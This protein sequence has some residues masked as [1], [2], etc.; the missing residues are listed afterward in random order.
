MMNPF[1]FLKK[2]FKERT[3]NPSTTT[4]QKNCTRV[5]S[6]ISRRSWRTI[7]MLVL[8]AVTFCVLSVT[9]WTM[10]LS[11]DDTINITF[12]SSNEMVKAVYKCAYEN[13]DQTV[14]MVFNIPIGGKTLLQQ[15]KNGV[16]MSKV[17]NIRSNTTSHSRDT[18]TSRTRRHH[19]K[20]K[21][22]ISLDT[23]YVI[24]TPNICPVG[25]EVTYLIIVHSATAYFAR[26]RAIRETYGGKKLF[27][28][29][30]QRVVFLLGRTTD[31]KITRSI[32]EEAF[33][34]RDIVQGH[35]LDSYHNL[36]HKGV[37]GYRWISEHCPQA[38]FIIK[39]DDDVFVN[40]FTLVRNILP[41]FQ[42]K[43]RHIVCHLRRSGTSPIIRGKSK[44]QVHD[45][46]FRGLEHFPFDYCNGYFVIITSDLIRPMLKAARL[47]PFFWIDDVYL[48]GILPATVGFTKFVDIKNNLT[49]KFDSGKKCYQEDGP[50]CKYV[51]VSQWRSNQPEQFW[52]MVLSNLT[53]AVKRELRVFGLS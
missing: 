24:N 6:G 7:A 11:N 34:N 51:A 12:A 3:F 42:N 2:Q 49:L 23:N 50:R 25:Q 22:P 45:D 8:Y 4:T 1:L 40:P 33:L 19:V 48:F 27:G 13:Q 16:N 36:T 21:Y 28:N 39:I 9:V 30:F 18:Q 43:T 44:W 41:A 31:P 14:D 47:N 32:Q 38:K 15:N 26:R 52:Y 35:F 5:H 46:E 20:S 10:F 17:V 53:M 37:L 29:I